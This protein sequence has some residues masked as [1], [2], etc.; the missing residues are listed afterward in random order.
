MV[1]RDDCRSEVR[2]VDSNHPQHDGIGIWRWFA[3]LP[4]RSKHE[5]RIRWLD[6]LEQLRLRQDRVEDLHL[7]GKDP[8][9]REDLD[10]TADAVL[11]PRGGDDSRF[12]SHALRGG[13]GDEI[14]GGVQ[15]EIV[16]LLLVGIAEG[17]CDGAENGSV[18]AQLGTAEGVGVLG[19]RRLLAGEGSGDTWVSGGVRVDE[20]EVLE[21]K[22]RWCYVYVRESIGLDCVG[23]HF[24]FVSSSAKRHQRV[25]VE[26]VSLSGDIFDIMI[27]EGK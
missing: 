13:E 6:G 14:G 17:G 23:S 24:R 12:R 7:P 2:P 15:G 21:G 18:A 9:E 11:R 22:V 25:R 26:V 27:R 16:V 1:Q 20:L 8:R 5:L 4:R 3:C 10:R 19:W